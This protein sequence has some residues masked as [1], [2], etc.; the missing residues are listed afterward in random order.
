MYAAQEFAQQHAAE[1]GMQTVPSQDV[2]FTEEAGYTTANE[3]KR[4]GLHV[5]KLSGT[6]FRK[7]L[8]SGEEIPSWFAFESVVRVLREHQQHQQ[9]PQQQ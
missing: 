7:L 1:L 2:V 6:K 3:A 5:C 8:R 4:R 9:L